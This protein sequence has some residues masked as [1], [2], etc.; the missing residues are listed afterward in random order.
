MEGR[1]GMHADCRT[2]GRNHMCPCAN[3]DRPARIAVAILEAVCPQTGSEGSFSKIMGR[4]LL[5]SRGRLVALGTRT[6]GGFTLSVIVP[7]LLLPPMI[8]VHAGYREICD[9]PGRSNTKTNSHNCAKPLPPA[10]HLK[11]GQCCKTRYAT[12]CWSCPDT[13]CSLLL[14][15]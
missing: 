5:S 4:L 7:Y 12:R 14:D 6:C 15:H 11:G 8:A 10:F 13:P 9:S 3:K 1:C 2:D